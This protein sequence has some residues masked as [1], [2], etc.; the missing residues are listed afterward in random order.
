[1]TLGG[2]VVDHGGFVR[3]GH[4][5][6]AEGELA[7]VETVDGDLLWERLR[8][9]PGELGVVGEHPDL[10]DLSPRPGAGGLR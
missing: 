4:R 8:G 7:V 5:G 2:V 1:V 6:G 3:P 9:T 10:A